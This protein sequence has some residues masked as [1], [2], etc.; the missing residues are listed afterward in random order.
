MVCFLLAVP[1]AMFM[2]CAAAES[3]TATRINGVTY[4]GDLP[5]VVADRRGLFESRNL[6]A[7]VTYEYSGKRNLELL[8]AGRTDIALMA[9]T[10]LV[11]DAVADPDPGQPDDPVILA[12]LVHSTQLNQIVV[13][14]ESGIDE[15]ADLPGRRVGLMKGTNAEFVWWLFAAYHRFDPFAATLVDLPVDE[16]SDAL[17]DGGVDAVVIWEPWTSRL[18]H[19]VGGRL[20]SFTGSNVYT[21]KWVVAARRDFVEREPERVRAVLGAYREAIE[22]IDRDPAAAMGL[23][24][25]HDGIPLDALRRIWDA[26]IYELSLDWSLIATLQQQLD[27]ARRA[28]YA[29]S[30]TETEVLKMIAPAP[31]SAVAP[32]AVSVPGIEG[33]Q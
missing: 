3:Q 7:T 8:R 9:L 33:R 29:A 24:A 27:W 6:H 23:Y 15:P 19:A 22:F 18:R 5:T 14:P 32:A 31:L 25:D 30:G 16:L 1:L 28:G 12:S 26:L 21:A 2:R 17:I 13:L 4:L 10:P 11:L 20:R